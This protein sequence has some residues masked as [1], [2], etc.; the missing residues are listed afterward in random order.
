MRARTRWFGVIFGWT[1]MGTVGCSGAFLLVLVHGYLVWALFYGILAVVSFGWMVKTS[2][3]YI[4]SVV[5]EAMTYH[6]QRYGHTTPSGY[7]NPRYAK[8]ALE[9][10]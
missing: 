9:S 2:R 3:I 1:L 7:Y 6:L 10:D 4:R 5:A 8:E